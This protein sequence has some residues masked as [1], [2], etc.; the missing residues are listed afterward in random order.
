M[1]LPM[2]MAPLPL[3]ELAAPELPELLV[4]PELAVPVPAPELLLVWVPELEPL[5]LELLVVR[6][7]APEPPLP[8]DVVPPVD[9]AED[10]LPLV[11]PAFAVL[12]LLPLVPPS[13]DPS[14]WLPPVFPFAVV[15]QPWGGGGAGLEQSD[16]APPTIAMMHV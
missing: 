5:P 2:T 12:G 10:E 14:A 4:P 3:P 16:A 1:P 11:L 13:P 9:P 15:F 6:V 8:L 7:P